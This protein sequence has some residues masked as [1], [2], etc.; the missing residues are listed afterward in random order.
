MGKSDRPG[1]DVAPTPWP[2]AAGL[3]AGQIW[4]IKAEWYNIF[5]RLPAVRLANTGPASIEKA[6]RVGRQ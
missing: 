1:R 2:V 5:A 4:R 3:R 6:L